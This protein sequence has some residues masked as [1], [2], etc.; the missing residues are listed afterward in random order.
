[1]VIEA[2]FLDLL[3]SVSW[4]WVPDLW[5]IN[6]LSVDGKNITLGKVITGIL[7]FI[8]GYFI[9]RSLSREIESRLLSRLD[10]DASLKHTLRTMIFYS[11]LVILTLFVLRL[12]N[13]PITIF[14]VLGGALA[15]GVGFGSQ[16]IVNNFI[17]GLIL[18]I[19]R[20]VRVGDIIETE[21][22]RGTVENIGARSTI[23][24]SMDNTHY[25]VPNSSFL[26]KNVLNWTLSD[27]VVRTKVL[28]GVAYGSNVR[29]VE[30]ML[31]EAVSGNDRILKYPE[32]MVLFSEFGDN[33]L[34][35][36]VYFWTRVMNVM[37][38]KL[39]ESSVRFRID[40]LF[41]ENNIVIA[42]PQR[43]VHIDTPRPL[44]VQITKRED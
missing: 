18:M 24:K 15:I 29:K 40:E 34:N 25:V 32:P 19:E 42:F 28:V 17:S 10:I 3:N 1:M 5:N 39:L 22:L 12:L 11:M 20:P 9:C 6:L 14:T 7:L 37:Q 30:E 38:L 16:N 44:Q 31:K 21:G 43:D 33:S 26:E 23:I 27:D 4:A 13:V 35:F 8:M 2:S 36:E 41:N